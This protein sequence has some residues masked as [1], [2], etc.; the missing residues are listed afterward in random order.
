MLRAVRREHSRGA[1]LI[2][3][4]VLLT[5]LTIMG[6]FAARSAIFQERSAANEADRNVALQ[7]AELTLRDAEKDILGL[8]ANGTPCAGNCRDTASY[9]DGLLVNGFDT[10]GCS[11]NGLCEGDETTTPWTTA[12]LWND[13]ARTAR[14]GQFTGDN[15]QVV[16]SVSRPPRYIIEKFSRFYEGLPNRTVYRI[17]VTAWGRN[18]NTMVTLQSVFV[19]Q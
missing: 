2:V 6:V 15:T 11:N 17:T 3:A 10:I 16:T 13:T 1:T 12:A 8:R 5:V 18:A 9:A 14:Y 19:P 4:L 7:A